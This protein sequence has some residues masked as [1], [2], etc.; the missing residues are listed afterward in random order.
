MTRMLAIV[1]IGDRYAVD[2]FFR[3]MR[4]KHPFVWTEEITRTMGG[5]CLE[6][7]K[8][9]LLEPIED[10]DIPTILNLA[11]NVQVAACPCTETD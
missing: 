9:C 3:E 8:L 7:A 11:E 5:C 10:S 6:K 2:G 1:I 4:K